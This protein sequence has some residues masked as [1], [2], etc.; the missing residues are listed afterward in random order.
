M[1]RRKYTFTMLSVWA[2]TIAKPLFAHEYYGK[3][4][5]IVHPWTNP[6]AQVAKHASVFMK[7]D[8]ISGSDVLLGGESSLAQSVEIWQ[9]DE[10]KKLGGIVLPESGKLELEQKGVHLKL[11]GLKQDLLWGRSYPMTL[12]FEKS[13][14]IQVMLS[15]GSH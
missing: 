8:E 6:T 13:G 14:A 12:S 7:F 15:V 4:F 9:G 11:I 5:V 1:N 2:T 10:L 3:S